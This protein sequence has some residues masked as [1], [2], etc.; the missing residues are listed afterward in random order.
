MRV[1]NLRISSEYHKIRERV[2]NDAALPDLAK[3]EIRGRIRGRPRNTL[4][5]TKIFQH[6]LRKKFP[7]NESYLS[8]NIT[9]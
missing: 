4:Q 2:R 1:A 8:I 9:P 6:I 3:Y 5:F 7:S